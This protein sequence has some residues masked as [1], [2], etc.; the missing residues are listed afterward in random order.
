MTAHMLYEQLVGEIGIPRDEFLRHMRM[1]EITAVRRGYFRRV[2]RTWEQT[3]FLAYYTLKSSM[4]DTS[5]ITSMKDLLT[6]P[7]IDDTGY[8]E[9]KDIPGEDEQERMRE[10]MRAINQ[11][12]ERKRLQAQREKEQIQ[13][14]ETP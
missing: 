8:E 14:Q 12:A 1:W 13:K 3:R 4:R 9:E 10:E 6:I 7:G 2:N 5:K 11:E